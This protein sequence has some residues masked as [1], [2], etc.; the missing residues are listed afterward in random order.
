MG[1]TKIPEPVWIQGFFVV[2]T[3]G[4]EPGTSCV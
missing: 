2:D 1:Q 4:L 3:P